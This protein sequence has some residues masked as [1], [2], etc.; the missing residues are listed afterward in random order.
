M[1]RTED[2]YSQCKEINADAIIGPARVVNGKITDIKIDENNNISV[3]CNN[4]VYLEY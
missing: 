3:L 1:D 4:G 2:V